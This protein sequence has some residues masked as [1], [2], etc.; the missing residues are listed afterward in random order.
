MPFCRDCHDSRFA[1]DGGISA[2]VYDEP[3]RKCIWEIK[4]RSDPD[5]AKRVAGLMSERLKKEDWFAGT[6]LITGV[7]VTAAKLK[8]RTFNQSYLISGAIADKYDI[9]QTDGLLTADD[10]MQDQ[11]GLSGEER[12]TNA[13]GH[14]KAN[15]EAKASVAGK[16]VLICDDV[17]TTGATLSACAVQLKALGA[18]K[19]YFATFAAAINKKREVK[20]HETSD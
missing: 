17:F 2:Y 10:G 3:A 15:R 9:I 19:V 16:T 14:I 5:S 18:E 11:I 12:F 20:K 13:S 4:Y 6:D 7:P 8:T 1:F